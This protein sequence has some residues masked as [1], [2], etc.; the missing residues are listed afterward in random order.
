MLELDAQTAFSTFPSFP[1]KFFTEYRFTIN[2]FF[3]P[4]VANKCTFLFFHS[5][6]DE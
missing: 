1:V 2:V 3:I 5:I 6:T 4:K